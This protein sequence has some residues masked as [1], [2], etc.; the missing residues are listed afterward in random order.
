MYCLFHERPKHLIVRLSRFGYA[1]TKH[2]EI[3]LFKQNKEENISNVLDNSPPNTQD[4]VRSYNPQ[5]FPA[6][7]GCC[8]HSAALS[9][10]PEDFSFSI[11]KA[12]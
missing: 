9:K 7:K 4:L 6:N 11:F 3:N 1:Q 2:P 5:P 8:Q 12:K 10:N